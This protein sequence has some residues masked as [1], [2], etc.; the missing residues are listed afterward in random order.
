MPTFILSDLA[1]QHRDALILAEYDRRTKKTEKMLMPYSFFVNFI[2]EPRLKDDEATNVWKSYTVRDPVLEKALSG[3]EVPD[4]DT[5]KADGYVCDFIDLFCDFINGNMHSE[6][7]RNIFRVARTFVSPGNI[8]KSIAREPGSYWTFLHEIFDI[9]PDYDAAFVVEF[10][11][12]VM[13]TLGLDISEPARGEGAITQIDEYLPVHIVVASKSKKPQYID[14]LQMLGADMTA[15]TLSGMTATGI[16]AR[17]D[18]Y[19]YVVP[20]IEIDKKYMLHLN[21]ELTD[22]NLTLLRRLCRKHPETI[23]QEDRNGFVPLAYSAGHADTRIFDMLLDVTEKKGHASVS[24]MAR[25]ARE[26]VSGYSEETASYYE[27]AMVSLKPYLRSDDA[28][29]NPWMEK[30]EDTG[31]AKVPVIVR[32]S[33]S[34]ITL[35]SHVDDSGVFCSSK[36]LNR[37]A[38]GARKFTRKYVSVGV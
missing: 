36:K 5:L 9:Q 2:N 6:Y 1:V 19:S 28:S 34:G 3:T 37:V 21:S 25:I 29:G 8:T 23:L 14:V 16:L 4:V 26:C 24:V 38:R 31:D 33:D 13:D 27:N 15:K 20:G 11:T 17:G 35:I 10:C 18:F 7:A 22:K 30:N 12:F 32:A